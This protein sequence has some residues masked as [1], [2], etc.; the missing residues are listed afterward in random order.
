MKVNS[1]VRDWTVLYY[2]NGNNDLEPKLVR[3]LLDAEAIGS[4]DRVDLVAQLSRSPQKKKTNLDGDWTGARRYHLSHADAKKGGQK[5]TIHSEVIAELPLPDQGAPESLRDF[6]R[7]GKENYPAKHTMVVIGDHG[8]GFVGTGYDYANKS[9]LNL[10]E[11]DQA[12][13]ESGL[14][15]DVLVF[16]ACLMG[17]LEVASQLRDRAGILV[18]SEEIVGQDGLPHRDIAEYLV[19]QPQVSPTELAKAVVAIAGQD[20]LDR[21]DEGKSDAAAQLAALRLDRIGEVEEAAD[22]LA[23]AL[24]KADLGPAK[25]ARARREA[26]QFAADT[27]TRPEEDFRDLGHFARLLGE[28][29]SMPAGVRKAAEGVRASLDRVL[30]AHSNE[31]EGMEEAEGLSVYLPSKL[32]PEGKSRPGGGPG[33]SWGYRQTDFAANTRWDEWLAS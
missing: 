17:Q 1:P 33:N 9:Q 3:N 16:D 7:W 23:R 30:L 21:I 15:P 27:E 22:G 18:A 28:D 14:K 2:L 4:S 10:L 8:K 26:T 20:E 12:L 25:V 31:G 11:L 29:E 24:E 19:C 13:T 32:K 5:K 6:L